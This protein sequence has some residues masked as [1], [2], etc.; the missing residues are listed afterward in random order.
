MH[1]YD[2]NVVIPQINPEKVL[3]VDRG[4]IATSLKLHDGRLK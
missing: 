1:M 3:E 4:R 2:E